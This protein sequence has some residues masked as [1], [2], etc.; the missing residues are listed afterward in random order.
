ME[1]IKCEGLSKSYGRFASLDS[2]DLAV[3]EGQVFGFLG[4][5]GAGK[6]T[7]VKLLTGLG[8]PT[9]GRAWVAGEPVDASSSS[10]RARIGYLPEEPAFYNWMA[11]HE[12]LT[13][14]GQLFGLRND[15][16]RR[17]SQELVEQVGLQEASR[18]RIGGYSR[19]MRQR[20][21]LAQAL[22]N[23]PRVLFLDE[24]CSALDPIG[25][26]EVL[27]LITSLRDTVTVFM[28]TH[29]LADVERVCDRV[30]VIDHG[31]LVIQASVE[32]L[33]QRYA[34]PVFELEFAEQADRFKSTLVA[35]PWVSRVESGSKNTALRIFAA[36]TPIARQSLP[37]LAASSGLTLLRYEIVAPSL[38]EIFVALVGTRHSGGDAAWPG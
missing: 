28:S 5:N 32:E 3:E 13:H 37:A 21:G 4:P 38:E 12:F 27:E 23:R 25:R 6:T 2:L 16:A 30:G 18:R 36:D 17:R 24:P 9:R 19:G 34:G 29:I 20:L 22:V 10:F 31:R 8:R 26:K 1:A 11:G 15:D 7:T 35:L 14:V 33:R